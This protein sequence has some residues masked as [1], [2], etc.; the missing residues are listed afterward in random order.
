M[1]FNT[2]LP[3]T[4]LVSAH[5][6]VELGNMCLCIQSPWRKKKLIPN[7]TPRF[8]L[9]K[10]FTCTSRW[11]QAMEHGPGLKDSKLCHWLYIDRRL[12]YIPQLFYPVVLSSLWL[13]CFG[14]IY[15]V[16]SDPGVVSGGFYQWTS[17]CFRPSFVLSCS[18]V[19]PLLRLHSSSLASAC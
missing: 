11:Y 5:N 14:V 19:P 4:Q 18:I 6:T 7:H 2:G 13:D 16:H 3:Y 8:K 1:R 15:A 9:A 17:P 10:I 12:L